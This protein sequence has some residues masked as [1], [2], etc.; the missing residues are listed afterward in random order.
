MMHAVQWIKN[1]M[2]V[3]EMA[4]QERETLF[5]HDRVAKMSADESDAARDLGLERIRALL[6]GEWPGILSVNDTAA[7]VEFLEK[8]PDA[9]K[10][11]KSS[12]Y[13]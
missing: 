11:L 9:M 10:T 1:L 4:P 6:G 12:V 2:H 3:I 8:H 13:D 7:M 5:I